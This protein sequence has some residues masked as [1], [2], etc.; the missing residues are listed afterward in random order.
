VRIALAL[1]M[2]ACA[3]IE[4]VLDDAAIDDPA[5]DDAAVEE[6]DAASSGAEDAIDAEAHDI[7]ARTASSD[8]PD[9]TMHVPRTMHTIATLSDGRVIAVGGWHGA[10]PVEEIELFDP[11]R[12]RWEIAGRL[13]SARRLPSVTV[14]DDGRVLIAGGQ[15]VERTDLRAVELFDPRTGRSRSA[16]PM[17]DARTHHSATLLDDGR[18]M[19]AGG[20]GAGYVTTA[21]AEI[22]DP[23]AN[24]W[25]P[26]GELATS[27][28]LHTATLLDDGRVMIAG[29][30]S[31]TPRAESQE[32]EILGSIELWDGAFTRGPSMRVARAGHRAVRAA[33]G[34]VLIVGG[35]VE[36]RGSPTVTR[37]TEL[38]GGDRCV[39]SGSMRTAR[40]APVVLFPD[41]RVW[42]GGGHSA[43]HGAYTSSAE[44][45]VNGRFRSAPPLSTP[46]AYHEVALL[47]DGRLLVVGGQLYDRARD[48]LEELGTAEILAP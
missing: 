29:G 1:L 12:M 34:R 15:G 18:V 33:D 16:A 11:A 3:E 22:Y 13:L 41:G 28:H 26:A 7:A 19:I 8:A 27:R 4:L 21:R 48:H 44:L 42:V 39:A 17:R 38:C 6:T 45:W 40:E 9:L 14:L 35:S 31:V 24:S 46:R 23:A 10:I 36:A 32:L 5:I 43:R 30:M 37:T 2:T 20:I 25:S 47:P